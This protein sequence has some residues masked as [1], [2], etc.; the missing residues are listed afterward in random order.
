MFFT[1]VWRAFSPNFA[2]KTRPHGGRL[3]WYRLASNRNP[4]TG[5]LLQDAFDSKL[6]N[7]L[8]TRVCLIVE[9]RV[10]T[11]RE[12]RYESSYETRGGIVRRLP[13]GAT[14]RSAAW[15]S[16]VDGCCWW[17][18][19]RDT[20]EGSVALPK[21]HSEISLFFG[22]N[23]KASCDE[24]SNDHSQTITPKVCQRLGKLIKF[25]KLI[26]RKKVD[27]KLWVHFSA[28]IIELVRTRSILRSAFVWLLAFDFL[29]LNSLIWLPEYLGF[30][31]FSL[32]STVWL[33]AFDCQQMTLDGCLVRSV[34]QSQTS[35]STQIPPSLFE[36]IR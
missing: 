22:W 15:S 6:S 1:K 25:I 34:W 36:Q 13:C 30:D 32:T 23:L 24:R 12:S 4:V 19:L 20:V 31:F 27:C 26:K 16:T 14:G 17:I 3:Q 9:R 8:F 28:L 11:E 5:I 10:C 2:P 35:L 29:R 21:K 18:L 7:F 33:L